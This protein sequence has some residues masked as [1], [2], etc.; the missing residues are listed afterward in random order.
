MSGNTPKPRHRW[1]SP[2][3]WLEW[4]I[5]DLADRNELHAI[6]RE[7]IGVVD[8]DQIQHLFQSDMTK[9]GYFRDL[10]KCPDCDTVLTR[11]NDD[12]TTLPANYCVECDRE[13]GDDE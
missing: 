1:D 10:N 4:K 9:D 6:I 11:A 7:L 3:E 12:T 5:A 8:G 13:I 2:A